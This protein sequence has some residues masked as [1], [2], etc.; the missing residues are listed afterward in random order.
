M[1][2]PV[3]EEVAA[4]PNRQA[5]ASGWM[6]YPTP[7]RYVGYHAQEFLSALLVLLRLEPLKS[8]NL[9]DRGAVEHL[10]YV[11]LQVSPWVIADTASVTQL[12]ELM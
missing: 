9:M 6:R 4:D 7:D 5:G 8:D 12:T 11:I 3:P 2:V 10:H 1:P